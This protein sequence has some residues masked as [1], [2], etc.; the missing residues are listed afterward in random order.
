MNNVVLSHEEAQMIFAMMQSG[1]E[2]GEVTVEDLPENLKQ[3]YFKLGGN[4]IGDHCYDL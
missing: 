2:K 4:S 3:L 1:M